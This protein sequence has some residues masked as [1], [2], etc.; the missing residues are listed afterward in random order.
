M[1]RV[2]EADE[3]VVAH[4]SDA[5][6]R[7]RRRVLRMPLI[8]TMS[9]PPDRRGA[10]E[11]GRKGGEEKGAEEKHL[12]VPHARVLVEPVHEQRVA[13]ERQRHRLCGAG[14]VVKRGV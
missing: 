7:R 12:V 8:G 5:I 13:R 6:E 9:Q 2:V 14:A 3:D 11:K 10:E 4:L 1:R